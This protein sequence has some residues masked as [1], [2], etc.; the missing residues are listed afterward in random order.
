MGKRL[1]TNSEVFV[2]L[3]NIL[4]VFIAFCDKNDFHPYLCAGTLLG[5]IRHKGFIP[6][7]DDIDVYLKRSEFDR[8]ITNFKYLDKNHQYEITPFDEK[9][10][11]FLF[12][13]VLNRKISIERPSA[14]ED[15]PENLWID[16]F[17]VEEL[18]NNKFS[19]SIFYLFSDMNIS[20]IGLAK[21]EVPEG[22]GILRLVNSI[23][24][25]IFKAIGAKK[26][27]LRQIKHATKYKNKDKKFVGC[28]TW[29]LHGKNE[30]MKK[31]EYDKPV[32][33]TF[34]GKEYKTMSCYDTYLR[35]L[36]GD[37]Y[38]ELPPENKRKRHNYKAWIEE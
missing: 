10:G 9:N 16:V 4:D 18:P 7:D 13:K 37:S 24:G 34:N 25:K 32:T 28:V 23:G 11:I 20:W 17:P 38:M 29:A 8:L 22:R 15:E 31:D 36:Y 12:A 33:V 14:L 2:E 5:A 6:W 26:L 3:Q 21:T 1:L 27:L 35:G 19:R 30:A